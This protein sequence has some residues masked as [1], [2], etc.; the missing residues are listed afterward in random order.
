MRIAIAVSSLARVQSTWTTA[1]IAQELISAGCE[2]FIIEPSNFEVEPSGRLVARG[3][4]LS[5]GSTSDVGGEIS[6]SSISKAM[7]SQSTKRCYIQMNTLDVLILR[8]NPIEHGLLAFAQLVAMSGVVVANDPRYLSLAS[9]KAFLST[10]PGVPTPRGLI[11]RDPKACHNFF[12]D[13][14]RGVVVKPARGSG[15]IGV[16]FVR[17]G[18]NAG[19]VLAVESVRGIGD[20]YAVV[21]EYLEAASEGEKR[22]FFMGGRLVG[23]YLRERPSGEFRHNLKQGGIPVGCELD[24]SDRKIE[25]SLRAHLIGVG[26]WLAGVDV[27][28][29]TVIEVNTLNPG[30]LHQI[31]EKT[32]GGVNFQVAKSI[33]TWVANRKN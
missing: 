13:K 15:G 11:S 5:E 23:A 17:A 9:H 3:I 20:G 1:I 29:G 31:N 7:T 8:C 19:L 21:Q 28:G 12:Q 10:V 22:L 26:A 32:D 30:G 16:S 6:P 2:L 14:K 33:A 27:I 25:E 24:D 4:S 18:D